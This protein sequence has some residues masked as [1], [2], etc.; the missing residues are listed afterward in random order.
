MTS[1]TACPLGLMAALAVLAAPDRSCAEEHPGLAFEAIAAAA[2]SGEADLG[3]DNSMSWSRAVTRFEAAR[4]SSPARSIGVQLEFGRTG[5]DF[6][7]DT[8]GQDSLDIDEFSLSLPMRIPLGEE[9]GAFLTPSVSY[10]GESGVDFDEGA[11]YGL[12]AGVAWRLGPDLM[13]GP[14]LG[15][16]STLRDETAFFPFLIVDW[17]FAERWSLSTGSG[18]AA[19]RGPGLRLAHHASDALEFGIEA[20]YEQFEFR[21]D[22]DHAVSD[23]I[24]TDSSIPVVVT[25]RWSP[26]DRVS[27]SGF[28]GVA[29][30]GSITF[31]DEDDRKVYDEDYDAAPLV[32][33]AARIAF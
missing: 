8:L 21:L 24:G 7:S 10:A 2:A 5:Y 27:V 25:G 19:S 26:N 3:D 4:S 29:L 31:D 32:G 20:R 17:R 6:G 15:A 14:A 18:F 16:Q 11:S 23:G 30:A 12:L 28:A 33:V 22:E 9:A 1:I 13:L